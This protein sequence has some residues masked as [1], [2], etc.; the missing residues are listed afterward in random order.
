VSLLKLRQESSDFDLF[1]DY[2]GLSDITDAQKY[3]DRFSSYLE[4]SLDPAQTEFLYKKIEELVYEQRNLRMLEINQRQ[5]I[6]SRDDLRSVEL[7]KMPK[8]WYIL[9]P[10][11]IDQ[12]NKIERLV[13][14]GVEIQLKDV[15][16]D[17]S[18]VLYHY[19]TTIAFLYNGV[20]K[21]ILV[22]PYQLL[23]YADIGEYGRI[24]INP[25]WVENPS[26]EYIIFPLF[27]FRK[28]LRTLNYPV[29]FY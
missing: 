17:G 6:P 4:Y 13:D 22:N 5:Y 26:K 14:T 12:K 25:V 18:G 28:S 27:G 7:H 1:I 9:I 19:H 24:F 2:L 8:G 23:D 11:S 3:S 15:T 20:D 29:S 21:T 10:T 16:L